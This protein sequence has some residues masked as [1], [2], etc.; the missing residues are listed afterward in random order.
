MLRGL[1]TALLLLIAT[2]ASAG[3][4]DV[5][6]DKAWLHETVKGQRNVNVMLNLS[7]LK[8]TRVLGISSPV[9]SGGEIRRFV[10]VH[11]KMEKR[12]VD[13]V[14]LRARDT[15]SFGMRNVYLVLTGLQQQLNEGEHIALKLVVEVAGRQQTIDVQAEVR[16]ADLSY[17]DF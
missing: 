6:V 9:A 5:M 16:A 7:V 12:A 4:N 13:S 2:S 10:R 17:Q 1:L 15:V 3:A 8:P 11:G 14:K